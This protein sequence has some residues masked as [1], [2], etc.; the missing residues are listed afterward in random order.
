MGKSSNFMKRRNK[1][2]LVNLSVNM[3]NRSQLAFNEIKIPLAF[4]NQ[5][6]EIKS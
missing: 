5:E 1:R 4:L 2:N 6:P 3:P